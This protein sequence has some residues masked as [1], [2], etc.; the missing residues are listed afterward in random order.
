[1]PTHLT[2]T[3]SPFFFLDEISIT[4]QMQI[5]DNSVQCV[6]F[7]TY[8]ASAL[9][10]CFLL[11]NMYSVWIFQVSYKY[12]QGICIHLIQDNLFEV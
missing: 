4:T 11:H 1:M 2:I 12:R 9:L 6:P 5:N 3:R 7:Y 10:C 8:Q